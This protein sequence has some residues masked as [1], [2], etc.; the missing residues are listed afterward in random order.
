VRCYICDA[1]I[2]EPK[3]SFT[4]GKVEPCPKCLEVAHDCYEGYKVPVDEDD[5]PT[6]VEADDAYDDLGLWPEVDHYDD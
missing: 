2:E 3:I 4:T 5:I 6:P 1:I